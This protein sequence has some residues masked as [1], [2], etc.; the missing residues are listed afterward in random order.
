VASVKVFG[1]QELL[2]LPWEDRPTG[3][4]GPLW[5]Y[6]ANPVIPR[7]L[8][9]KSNSIFNSAVVP[10][11]GHFAGVFRCDDWTRRMELHAGFSADGLDWEISPEPLEFVSDDAEIGRFVYGYDPR[12]VRI[13]ERYYVTWCNWYHGPTIG[14][15]WTDDFQNFHQTEN[16]YLPFNRNGV[17][18]PR[19]IGGR[20]AMLSRPSDDGHTP[21]GD[22]FYSESPDLCFWG[23]HRHVMSPVANSWQST[24]VGGG[25]VPIETSEGWLLMYHGVLTSCNGFVY[26]AGVALLDPDEPWKVIA[27]SA[28]YV[29]NPRTAYE[30]VGDV[31]NVVF[32][33]A[34]LCDEPTGRLAVY[35]GAADTVT[36]LAF[37]YVADL[38]EFAKDQSL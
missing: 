31:P 26:S 11:E 4:S 16:A 38:V 9:P 33:C 12:V 8:L 23:K 22:I 5:R 10:F 20:F 7:D 35:Y 3:S 25:P 37:G 30:C 1:Q 28:P 13:D 17:L 18:F 24:K 27:R 34:M 2:N 21:F 36:A 19:K 15:A 14:V 29:L 32:P 6:S